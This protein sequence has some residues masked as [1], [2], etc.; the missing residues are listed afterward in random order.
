MLHVFDEVC[1]LIG[2]DDEVLSLVHPEIGDGPFS[3]VLPYVHFPTFINA[4]SQISCAQ[5]RLSVGDLSFDVQTASMWNPRPDWGRLRAHG[6]RLAEGMPDLIGS[7]K[8]MAPPESLAS[9]IVSLSPPGSDLGEMIVRQSHEPAGKLITG[10]RSGDV[11]RT[12]EGAAELV[13]LGEGLTPAG[14]D[15]ISG[16]LLGAQII[17]GENEIAKVAA[18]I[19]QDIAVKTTPLSAAMLRAAARGECSAPWH[20]LLEALLRVDVPNI[21]ISAERIMSQ[22]HTSGADALAG[23]AAIL[24]EDVNLLISWIHERHGQ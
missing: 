19:E 13:G 2:G 22:G 16:C 24:D 21:H 5:D 8:L 20:D 6:R 23:F 10:L 17:L 11:E 3:I 4:S 1:N 14:D 15:W 9:L 18:V 12:R 7:I